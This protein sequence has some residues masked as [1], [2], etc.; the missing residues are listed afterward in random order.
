MGLRLVRQAVCD[1]PRCGL[2]VFMGNQQTHSELALEIGW[3]FHEDPDEWHCP[4][5]SVM[6]CTAVQA[7]REARRA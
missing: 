4:D 2:R 6:T 7:A 1:K 3:T 5:C